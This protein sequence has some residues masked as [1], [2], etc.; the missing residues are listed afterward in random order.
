MKHQNFLSDQPDV[1]A[2]L[3]ESAFN[4]A[5]IG[6]ALVAPDGTWLMVNNALCSML[7]YS[8]SELTTKT[9]QDITHPDD[10]EQDLGYVNQMLAG[11]IDTYKLEKRYYHK[12]NSIIDILLSVSMV[13]NADGSPRLFVS[14][15][16][17]ITERKRLEK[18]LERMSQEDVLTGVANRRY[19]IEHATREVTRGKRFRE[20]QAILM[21]DIDRFK[22]INDTYGHKTGD[23]V[24]RCVAR[25][26]R[27]SVREI[28]LFGRVGGEEF[29]SVLLNVNHEKA[30][31]LAERL[32]KKIEELPIISKDESLYCTIS[33]GLVT[34]NQPDKSLEELMHI[35]DNALYKAKDEGRNRVVDVDMTLHGIS[36]VFS[37]NQLVRIEWDDDYMSGNTI[38][39]SQHRNLFLYSN[40]ILN[41]ITS[42]LND[43][44]ITK[45][46]N[47]LIEHAKKH[48]NDEYEIIKETQYPD[49]ARHAQIHAS[50]IEDMHN[51]VGKFEAG[52]KPVGELFELLAVKVVSGHML[53][54]DVKFFEYL[55]VDSQTYSKGNVTSQPSQNA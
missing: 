43:S 31:V 5:A 24:L 45:M 44:E 29:A 50:L 16:Q 2:L 55:K 14:Q 52:E 23:I 22:S 13:R 28:D 40:Q 9:F 33:I 20:N 12:N 27:R 10:L 49:H 17:D 8:A 48:F 47:K 19:F 51:I 54:E 21:I 35:A 34:F 36:D 39:D 1:D 41:A 18:Q 46:T 4:Y 30:K 26:C 15:I 11:D 42:G 37:Q 3:F 7:G 32:R 53:H 38:I 25:E 6:M